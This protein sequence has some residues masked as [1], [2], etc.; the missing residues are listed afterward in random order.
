MFTIGNHFRYTSTY[1]IIVDVSRIWDG[2]EGDWLIIFLLEGHA[3][4]GETAIGIAFPSKVKGIVW[5]LYITFS[6]RNYLKSLL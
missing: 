2:P 4:G 5:K 1:N 3:G 6:I